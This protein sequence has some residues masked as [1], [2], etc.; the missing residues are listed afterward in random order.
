MSAE[1]IRPSDLDLPTHR[2]ANQSS[3]DDFLLRSDRQASGAQSYGNNAQT[4]GNNAQSYGN[5]AQTNGKTAQAY[6]DTARNAADTI[7]NSQVSHL[8]LPK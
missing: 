7:V 2:D 4:Y 8:I 1:P 3:V 6:Q 5:N